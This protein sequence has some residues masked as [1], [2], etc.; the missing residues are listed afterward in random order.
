MARQAM[1]PQPPSLRPEQAIPILEELVRNADQ[2][3]TEKHGSPSRQEWAHTGE[4]ALLAALGGADNAISAFGAAQCGSY[5]PWDTEESLRQQANQQLDGMLAV[6][7]SAIQQLRWR[8]PDPRQ[9]FIPAGSQHDAY[10][11]IRSIVQQAVSEI[12]VVDPWV[13]ET[14]WPLLKNVPTTCR[15]RILGE[16]LKGDFALEARRFSAQHGAAIEIRRTSN[17]HDRFIFLDGKRCVHLG[18][19]IKDAGRKAFLL[20]EVER[21]QI[22]AATLAD[23]EAAWNR[24][25]PV[26]I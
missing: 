18:A 22:V 17:Y 9:V 1:A 4:G 11:E 12:F 23:S 8:L 20:S 6:L 13:D 3:R 24:A 16:H 2:L 10:V 25:A 26:Q 15:V 19:S 7:R 21:P 5:G 14:L